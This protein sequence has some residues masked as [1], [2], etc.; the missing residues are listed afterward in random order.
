VLAF[1]E[2]PKHRRGRLDRF[3]RR[4]ETGIHSH[5]Q[6]NLQDLVGRAANIQGTADVIRQLGL[7]WKKR[8]H[9]TVSPL[10]SAGRAGAAMIPGAA[11]SKVSGTFVRKIGRVMA[12]AE[13]VVVM[14]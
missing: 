13:R 8:G 1:F 7:R 5:L 12:S 10:W 4:G 3:E 6:N 2:F 14:E 9:S 11:K